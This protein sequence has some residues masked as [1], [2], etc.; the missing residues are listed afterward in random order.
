MFFE[1]QWTE[2]PDGGTVTKELTD[3]ADYVLD[4]A[5]A[6]LTVTRTHAPISSCGCARC[7]RMVA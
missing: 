3:D 2:G 7:V 4:M 5:L 1:I 6:G